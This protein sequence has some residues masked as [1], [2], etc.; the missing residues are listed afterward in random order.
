MR[1]DRYTQPNEC[2]YIFSN[3]KTNMQRAVYNLT[4]YILHTS[5][6]SYEQ[7]KLLKFSFCYCSLSSSIVV[8]NPNDE[9]NFG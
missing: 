1:R 4:V 6:E 9:M 2:N 7:T 5:G 3:L 8:L